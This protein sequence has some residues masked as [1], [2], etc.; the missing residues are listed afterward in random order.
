MSKHWIFRMPKIIRCAIKGH[1]SLNVTGLSSNLY[2]V[3]CNKC[4]KEVHMTHAEYKIAVV[5]R[6][7]V[8]E[9]S[10]SKGFDDFSLV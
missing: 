1:D 6:S 7:L 2:R 5:S 3:K 4:E 8:E 10:K 9:F